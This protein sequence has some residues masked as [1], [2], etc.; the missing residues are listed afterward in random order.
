MNNKDYIT[1]YS[2]FAMLCYFQHNIAYSAYCSAY[3]SFL[4][5]PIS[6]SSDYQCLL[7]SPTTHTRLVL[8][9]Y[10]LLGIFQLVT[11]GY[12]L[13]GTDEFGKMEVQIPERE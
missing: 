7:L 10:R 5:L 3:V 4:L 8:M 9:T 12:P 11:D 13:P 2:T 6:K 1:L